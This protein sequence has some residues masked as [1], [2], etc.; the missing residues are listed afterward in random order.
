MTE[1]EQ[2]LFGGVAAAR[3]R[4]QRRDRPR[5]AASPSCVDR[6]QARARRAHAHRSRCATGRRR[7][8]RGRRRAHRDRA[9]RRLAARASSQRLLDDVVARGRRGAA[10]RAL[11]AAPRSAR[12]SP[13]A[14]EGRPTRANFRTGHLTICTLV[15]MR[16]VPHRVVCLLG[17]DD[18]VVP[19]QGAARRRRPDAAT[20]RTS[21]T[22]TPR[23]EDRQ[24][25]LDALHGRHRPADRHLHRQ[26]RAHERAA[27][28][29]R[30]GRRAA[31]RGRSH[32]PRRRRRPSRSHRR[33]ASAAAVRPAQLHRRRAAH[34]RAV[35]LRR[36][37]RWPAPARSRVRARR[38][39]PFLAGPAAGRRRPGGRGS[40]TSCASC[41]S[42]CARSCAGASA[43]RVGD[44]DDEIED[45]LPIELDD[46]EKYGVGKRLL[47]TLLARSRRRRPPSTPRSRAGS[48][49]RGALGQAVV[50]EVWP[51]V[52]AVLTCARDV[53]DLQ[54]EPESVDVRA[55]L[56]DGRTLS[57]TVSGVAGDVLRSI[58]YATL[59]PQ[60]R[61]AAWVRLVAL[62]AAH[63][64]RPF[65]AI[66][67][68][69]RRAQASVS[70]IGPLG[71][72]PESRRATALEYLAVLADLMDRGLREPLPMACK[73]SHAYAEAASKGFDRRDGGPRASGPRSS[74]STR[75]TR[76]PSTC[77]PSAASSPSES[78]SPRRRALT[79]ATGTPPT[80]RAS[81]S[82]LAACGPASSPTRRSRPG[83]RAAP[84]RRP[85]SAAR[86]A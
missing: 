58:S 55:I 84:L 64:E 15:P 3:R 60:H 29:G 12:C 22:A 51:K 79:S 17:L 13:S 47:D 52:G 23:S 82:S 50:D 72:D 42:R 85:R 73:T 28:A 49:R 53:L 44:Y 7:I 6:L 48:C 46:L 19:A 71:D 62:T 65:Q 32:G 86:P 77:W 4:R 26:R 36:A 45:A 37:R 54:A 20:T 61:I 25:L 8:A 69:R 9:A 81:A 33:R 10:R 38:R 21:A 43:S 35:E 56:A 2:R 24:L 59:G 78:C 68:G 70:R 75:R 16:S 83:E 18:G 30:A 67:V 80:G 1:D 76:S 66:T 27:A 31:R 11:G 41:S 39:P 34:R 74:A 40:T 57:G 14:C 63:P 5:R